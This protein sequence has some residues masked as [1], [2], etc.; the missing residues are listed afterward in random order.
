MDDRELARLIS[1]V[2]A[3]DPSVQPC[4]RTSYRASGRARVIGISGPPGAGKSTLVDKLIAH[5]RARGHRVAIIAIDPSSPFSGGAVLGDRVRMARHS[6]DRGVFIRSLAARGALGGLTAATA[7]V[8]SLL[9]ASGWDIILLE[10]VGVGQNEVEIMRVTPAV[11]IVQNPG[12]GDAVQS[13]KAGT[14][15]IAHV[16]AVNKADM[17]GAERVARDLNEMLG[18]KARRTS[19]GWKERVVL[20]E[21]NTGKGVDELA[22]AIDERFEFL[23][24]H[25]D[26]AR[27]EERDRLRARIANLAAHE[28]R[29]KIAALDAAAGGLSDIL[30]NLQDRTTDPHSVA[31]ELLARAATTGISDGESLQN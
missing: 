14:L 18:H 20:T 10:T 12:D 3:G 19:Q 30:D 15:E 2:E 29:R 23:Q 8:L 5:Y 26:I 31:A 6:A 17:D 16:F 7:D 27:A 1:R 24:A 28:L 9:D 13:V 25:P 11:V 4:L 22:A 21:A